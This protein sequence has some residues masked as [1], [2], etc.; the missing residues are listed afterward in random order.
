MKIMLA[1]SVGFSVRFSVYVHMSLE[2]YISTA[3]AEKSIYSG[4][5]HP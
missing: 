1:I 5:N 4:I 2:M 3:V